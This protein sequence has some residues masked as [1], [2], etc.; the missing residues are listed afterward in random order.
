MT[1]SVVLGFPFFC[2]IIPLTFIRALFVLSYTVIVVLLFIL[3]SE[4]LKYYLSLACPVSDIP[5]EF[6][7]SYYDEEYFAGSRGG[8]S[9]RRANGK[10]EHWSYF[11][12]AGWWEGCV[13]IAKAWKTIFNPKNMLDCGAGRGPFV[14]AARNEGIEAY[15]FDFSEWAVNEGRVE[16]CRADWLKLHDA[17]KPWP[18]PD[19]SFDL[20]TAL[21]FFEHIYIEDLDFVIAELYRVTRK[22]AFLQIAIVGGGSGYKIHEKGYILKKGEPIPH[23]LEGNLVAG[24]VLV[25]P[26]DWW[27]DKLGQWDWFPRR[28]L[29]NWFISLVPKEV[30]HN[31]LLNAII[32]LEK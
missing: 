31:W 27:Y 26:S 10:I 4:Y 16:G 7:A 29:V 18:W 12:P 28:D 9:F 11:N 20:C 30:L 6:N 22:W 14:L 24:H 2:S 17:T 21:D 15:G 19:N 32:V 8:K 3:F 1:L 25:Q 23:E 5:R 13:P